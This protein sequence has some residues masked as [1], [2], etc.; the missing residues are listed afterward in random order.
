[1]LLP[2]LRSL[3]VLFLSSNN[4]WLLTRNTVNTDIQNKF[5]FLGLASCNLKEFPG[6]L[7][8]QDQLELLDLSANKY[9][10]TYQN[11]LR[12]I[13]H[14]FRAIQDYVENHCQENVRNPNLSN[15]RSSRFRVSIWVWLQNCCDRLRE[16]ANNQSGS[17]TYHH[18]K[19]TWMVSGDISVAITTNQEKEGP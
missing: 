9:L 11:G 6:F 14:L 2:E 16:W 7:H 10:A 5:V 18:H 12:M 4:F 17:W 3:I 1:M 8:N 15:R 13:I 19:K